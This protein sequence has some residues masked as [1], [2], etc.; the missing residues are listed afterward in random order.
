[1]AI[2]FVKKGRWGLEVARNLTTESG[3]KKAKC[4]PWAGFTV[5]C[6][7]LAPCPP[8]V[9][10]LSACVDLGQLRTFHWNL[11]EVYSPL[12]L[13]ER[14]LGY[15]RSLSAADTHPSGVTTTAPGGVLGSPWAVVTSEVT[16]RRGVL[17]LTGPPTQQDTLAGGDFW[18]C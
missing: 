11:G 5:H 18:Q 13:W 15:C 16:Q 12:S 6:V 3:I 10:S 1:M 7:Q 9:T 14:P 17:N 2:A 8:G 4:R